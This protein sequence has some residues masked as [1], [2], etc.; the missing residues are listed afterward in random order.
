VWST[1]RQLTS[2]TWRPFLYATIR[3]PSDFSS[4][5]KP[6]RRRGLV[7]TGWMSWTTGSALGRD[8]AISIAGVKHVDLAFGGRFALPSRRGRQPRH[9]GG[10]RRRHPR[11]AARGRGPTTEERSTDRGLGWWLRLLRF[12][13]H[14]GI[15]P[16]AARAGV[17]GGKN[18]VIEYRD[19][20][21]ENRIASASWP[22][23]SCV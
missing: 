15:P 6:S 14:R 9:R 16:R 1:P 23:P 13:S 8:A 5:T 7:R 4:Y 21:R 19:M 10:P 17:R 3:L 20:Q 18:I 12:G 2:R 11:R 22:P